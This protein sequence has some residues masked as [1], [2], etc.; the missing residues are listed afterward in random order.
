MPDVHI[1]TQSKGKETFVRHFRSQLYE[2]VAWLCG[3]KMNSFFFAGHVLY[4]LRKNQAGHQ[5]GLMTYRICTKLKSAMK[6]LLLI[7]FP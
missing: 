5:Q 4:S 3:C 1:H 7:Y 6:I 2:N